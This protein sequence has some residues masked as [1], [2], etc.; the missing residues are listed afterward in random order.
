MSFRN[1]SGCFFPQDFVF[2]E[3]YP[4]AGI[5][6]EG[7]PVRYSFH[8]KMSSLWEPEQIQSSGHKSHVL[9]R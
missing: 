3:D 6:G 5:K 2:K 7:P 9:L 4:D 1:T 8:C